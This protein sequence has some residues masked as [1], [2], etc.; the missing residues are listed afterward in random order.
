MDTAPIGPIQNEVLISIKN[1]PAS[2]SNG[3]TTTAPCEVDTTEWPLPVTT[4][5]SA[6]LIP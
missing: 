1:G 5:G 3:T 2:D 4:E 6:V